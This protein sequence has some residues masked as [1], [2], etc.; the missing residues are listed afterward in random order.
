MTPHQ[1]AVRAYPSITLPAP[2]NGHLVR[3]K[4]EGEKDAVRANETRDRSGLLNALLR[5]N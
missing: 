2:N 1:N 3:G 5:A 4:Q